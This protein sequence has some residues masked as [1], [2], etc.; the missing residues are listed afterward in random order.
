MFHSRYHNAMARLRFR[1][2]QLISVLGRTHNLNA[3]ARQ[4]VMTQPAATKM[5]QEVEDIVG[6]RL[7]ERFPRGMRPTEVGQ[8]AVTYAHR[9]IDEAVKFLDDS[10]VMREGGHGVVR[11]GAI[12]SVVHR[13]L[14]TAI[15]DMKKLRPLVTIRLMT[16]TSD[17]LVIALL[18]QRLD[19]VIGRRSETTSSATTFAALGNEEIWLFAA[20]DHPLAQIEPTTADLLEESWVLQPITSPLRLLMEEFFTSKGGAPRS[21]VETT[22]VHATMQ[23]VLEAGMISSL[24]SVLLRSEIKMGRIR[25]LP[26]TVP[27]GLDDYG[28]I[29]RADEERPPIDQE[30]VETLMRVNAVPA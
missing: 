19:I 29:T 2:L 26:I 7:F 6:S 22:S 21:L 9:A 28:I 10:R 14:P 3:A 16:G 11:V 23:L 30:F 1:Q 13:L 24:P 25:R 27:A 18:Q 17:Q 15:A 4:M 5:L 20:A 8:L 12:T